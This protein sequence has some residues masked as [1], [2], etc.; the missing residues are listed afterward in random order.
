V[1][2]LSPP[3]TAGGA[4]TETV[5]HAFTDKL[6]DGANPY[7]GLIAGSK[8]NL[9]GATYYGGGSGSGTVF[10]VTGIGSPPPPPPIVCGGLGE[11]CCP[12][13]PREK[14][15]PPPPPLPPF[16][17][18]NNPVLLVC[19]GIICRCKPGEVCSVE[20]RPPQ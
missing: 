8:D 7:A 2:E 19:A 12:P 16:G 15:Q 4:W 20:P 18:C 11:I 9:Y 1:F 10:E 13:P 17:T 5:L 14:P 3:A 6:S